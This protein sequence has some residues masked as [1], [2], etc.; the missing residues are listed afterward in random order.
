MGRGHKQ[1]SDKEIEEI[2]DRIARGGKLAA[3]AKDYPISRQALKTR[4]NTYLK[5]KNHEPELSVAGHLN[6]KIAVQPLQETR[7]PLKEVHEPKIS[8][9]PNG[10]KVP[11]L[12]KGDRIRGVYEI[13]TGISHRGKIQECLD[14]LVL[15]LKDVEPIPPKWKRD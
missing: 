10:E 13:L 12:I 9:G 7:P 1:V 11:V 8:K 2:M 5:Q 4:I 3:I 6:T 15:F 14:D